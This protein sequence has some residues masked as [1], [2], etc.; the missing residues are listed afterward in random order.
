MAL[1]SCHVFHNVT[2]ARVL[3]TNP[4]HGH[5]TSIAPHAGGTRPEHGLAHRAMRRQVA[6]IHKQ[7]NPTRCWPGMCDRAEGVGD[8]AKPRD[9]PQRRKQHECCCVRTTGIP[10]T[11]TTSASN[12]LRVSSPALAKHMSC[13]VHVVAH[14]QQLSPRGRNMYWRRSICT[15]TSRRSGR[16]STPYMRKP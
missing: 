10:F 16:R 15:A 1:A 13:D 8:Q 5:A 4:S 3:V 6:I 2:T 14:A 12:A 7:G 9:R 11:F